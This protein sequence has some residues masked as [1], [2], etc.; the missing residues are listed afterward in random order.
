MFTTQK[1]EKGFTLV[2]MLVSMVIGIAVLG[3]TIYSYTKQDSVLRE[4]NTNVQFR[5]FARLALDA[6]VP[7]IRTTGY[8]MP[9]GDSSLARAAQGIDVASATT[10]TYKANTDD[11]TIYVAKDPSGATATSLVLPLNSTNG[12][13]FVNDNVAFFDTQYPGRGNSPWRITAINTDVNLGD[14]QNY[15]IITLN[16]QIGFAFLPIA[17]GVPVVVNKYHTININYNA[18]AQTITVTD[19]NGTDDGG[20]D[21]TTVI[22]A[23][24]VSDL[25]FSYFDTDGIALTSLPLILADR[26]DVRR[27]QIS[28][29]VV[30]PDETSKT[31]T[32]STHTHL[33]NMGL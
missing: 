21:D 12:A 15:D 29:T 3:V 23:N 13:M 19:D 4:E 33:R 20:G 31:A 25:T 18:G 24:N 14:P 28:V 32:L 2:E 16:G 26:G 30:N 7:D 11:I 9:P 22:V 10:L 17:N 8:G 1:N 6:M 5:D 27:I